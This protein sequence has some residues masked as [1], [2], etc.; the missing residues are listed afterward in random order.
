MF[1][2]VIGQEVAKKLLSGALAEDRLAQSLLFYGPDGVGKELAAMELAKAIN[3]QGGQ[4]DS[5]AL[6]FDK[7]SLTAREG[8]A[9]PPHHFGARSPNQ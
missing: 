8:E 3:C 4:N 7:L 9:L 5:L 2:N 6:D 1:D